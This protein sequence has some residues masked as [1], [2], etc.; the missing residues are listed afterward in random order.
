MTGK[1]NAVEYFLHV[2]SQI[3][4]AN[5]IKMLIS[6]FLFLAKFKELLFDVSR[7]CSADSITRIAR[8]LFSFQLCYKYQ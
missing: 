1:N 8:T 2:S 4:E 7:A 6:H 3:I 5:I